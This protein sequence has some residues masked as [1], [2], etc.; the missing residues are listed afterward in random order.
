V[1][2]GV[3]LESGS[4]SERDIL[5][6]FAKVS[7]FVLVFGRLRHILGMAKAGHLVIFWITSFAWGMFMQLRCLD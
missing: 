6:A 1:R 4:V 5:K 7:F 2:D 3:F